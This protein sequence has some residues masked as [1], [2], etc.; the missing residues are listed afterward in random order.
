[1]KKDL[2]TFIIQNSEIGDDIC[3]KLLILMT[4]LVGYLCHDNNSKVIIEKATVT[5]TVSGVK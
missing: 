2:S 5:F 1:M 3:M 4:V